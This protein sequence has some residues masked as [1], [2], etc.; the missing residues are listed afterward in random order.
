ME[1]ISQMERK[2]PTHLL[3]RERPLRGPRT[4]QVLPDVDSLRRRGN[5][6]LTPLRPSSPLAHSLALFLG[7]RWL[8]LLLYGLH[9]HA[10]LQAFLK[11]AEPKGMDKVTMI[12]T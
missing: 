8:P 3:R 4:R 5:G 7:R 12:R 2:G 6:P 9:A 1:N 11:A 10:H